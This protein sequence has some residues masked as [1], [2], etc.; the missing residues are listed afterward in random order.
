[1]QSTLVPELV[2]V[3]TIPSKGPPWPLLQ[4]VS[5]GLSCGTEQSRHS[6]TQLTAAPGTGYARLLA[7]LPRCCMG[8]VS[9][10]QHLHPGANTALPGLSSRRKT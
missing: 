8:S 3:V 2:L 7:V 5:A 4:E 9:T 6:H 10:S 1:M